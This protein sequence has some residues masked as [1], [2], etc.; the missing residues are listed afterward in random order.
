[1]LQSCEKAMLTGSD[2]SFLTVTVQTLKSARVCVCV[3][4]VVEGVVIGA[5]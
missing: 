2:L 3:F 1:M 4:S 5:V